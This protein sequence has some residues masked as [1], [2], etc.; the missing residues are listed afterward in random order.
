M[1]LIKI[2][3]SLLILASISSCGVKGPLVNSYVVTKL[4]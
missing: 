1:N 2:I 3:F 4:Q